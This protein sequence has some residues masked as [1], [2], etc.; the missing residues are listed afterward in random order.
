MADAV[1]ARVA[2]VPDW[3][4]LAAIVVCSAAFRVWLVRGMPAP[5]IFVDELI[6]SELARSLAHTGT[7]AV[8]GVATTGYSILYPALL[9]PAYGLVDGLPR[10]YA[11]AK[12]TN[13]VAMS[14]AAVPAWLITRR[15]AGRWLSLLAAVIA[16]AVPS[17]AYTATVVTENLFYP[18]ALLFGWT[19]VLVLERPSA[20]RILALVAALAASVATRSQAIGFVGAILLAPFLL[21]L[22]RRDRSVLR[23]FAPLL[24]GIVVLGVL[25]VVAQLARGRSL[26]DLLGA[27]SVVGEAGYDVGQVL[28]FW[29]WHVEE[30]ILYVAVVPVVALV[31]LLSGARQLPAAVQEH[32]AA[33]I[34]MLATSTLVVGAFASHFASDR[35]QDRY[36]FFL[37]PLLVAVLAAWVELGAPRPLVP[38]VAGSAL[39]VAL[40][41]AFPYTRFIGEPAKSDSLRV[42][43]ALVGEHAP[44]RRLVPAHRARRRAR[45]RRAVRARPRPRRVRRAA[46]PA[47]GLRRPFETCVVRPARRAPLGRRCALP[48]YPR[49][50][51]VAGSTA[52]SRAQDDVA[53]LWTG[54]ADRFTV[55][56]NEF[57]NRGGRRRLLHVRPTPGGIGETPVRVAADGDRAHAGRGNRRPALRLARRFRDAG[58][59]SRGARRPRH[60]A[61]AA[62]RPARVADPSDRPVSERHLVGPHGDLDAPSVH[63]RSP[64]RRPPLRSH[65]LRGRLTRV[66]ARVR[67]EPVAR[68][69][70]PP[71]GT[72]TLRVPLE[73]AGRR[74]RV[75]FTVTPTL[76]PAE[77][78]PGNTDDRGARG[79]FD[80][81]VHLEPK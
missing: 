65:A 11:A 31:V 41:V 39:A 18:V 79:H 9:A 8:R 49:A 67:G 55:N 16:V 29:L 54:R 81:F 15:V 34:A 53:V 62:E 20:G 21:A 46:C 33:T 6:Y 66:L 44:R 12:A 63:G 73:P 51:R 45:A 22:L 80:S 77:V 40:V 43:A 1:R 30:L 38:L 74:C 24:G 52:A 64:P 7:F 48:G 27:Y 71:E 13:A 35:V 57:F 17:M 10:A 4:W 56:Q 58:R 59:G 78:I 72:A 76:V 5:F 14:L 68:I 61:V 32:L 75:R 36:L 3:A 28:R 50:S 70:V 25:L 60:D 2:R 26:S 42:A 37:A 69:V 23:R 19:L 47:R